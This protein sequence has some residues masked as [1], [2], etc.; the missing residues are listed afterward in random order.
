MK[1]IDPDRN[2][3]LTSESELT[4]LKYSRI[5]TTNPKDSP[6]PG[7]YLFIEEKDKDQIWALVGDGKY[8]RKYF[9]NNNTTNTIIYRKL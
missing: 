3:Y 9:F 7:D 1:L 8:I 5:N 4:K 6:K 2:L